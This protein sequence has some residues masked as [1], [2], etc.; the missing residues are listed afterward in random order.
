MSFAQKSFL[1]VLERVT[2][3]ALNL[4][5]GLFIVVMLIT[6]RALV[7]API[8]FKLPGW[9]YAFRWAVMGYFAFA[10][11]YDFFGFVLSWITPSVDFL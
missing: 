9:M 5:A 8:P 7:N 11:L 6:A 3:L 4:E 1:A 2:S 10:I